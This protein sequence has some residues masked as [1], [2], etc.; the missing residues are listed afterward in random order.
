[1]PNQSPVQRET[2]QPAEEFARVPAVWGDTF[3]AHSYEVDFK[4]TA[5]L[6]NLCRRFQEA[7]WN[8]A[9][10]LGVGYERLQR[11]NKIWVLSRLA[12][13]VERYP[14]W[15]EIV[16]LQ[17]WPRTAKSVFAM[18][19]FEMVDTGGARLL[20]GASAWLVLDTTTRKPQR[21]DKLVSGIRASADRHALGHDPEKLPGCEASPTGMEVF[22][23]YSDIDVN[24]HVNNSKYIGWFLDSYPLDFHRHHAAASLEVNYL[25]ETIG[26]DMLSILSKEMG[27][28]QYW[29]S[30]VKSG[31]GIEVCRARIIW[32]GR[33][34]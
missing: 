24:G 33:M 10:A 12:M 4:K 23:R 20:G 2:P 9:E 29:H 15:G 22:V 25:G 6:E 17:T 13:K 21:V 8:H 3:V 27:A 32:D 16:K 26:G 28:G 31:T 14:K 5:T 7:A 19:D 18:R 30:I 34:E 1:M 11:E